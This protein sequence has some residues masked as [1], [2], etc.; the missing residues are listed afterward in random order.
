[1]R[2]ITPRRAF[3]LIEV[4]VVAVIL[5][6]LVALVLPAVQAARESARRADCASR[7]RQ[8]ALAVH[9]HAEARGHFPLGLKRTLG[10][11]SFLVQIL[12]YLEQRA[13]YEA[14]N[15][16]DDVLS[17]A[18]VTAL[19]QPP[20]VFLCPSD[21]QPTDGGLAPV[22]YAGN[23]GRDIRGG[24][25]VFLDRPLTAAEITDGLG[26]TAAVAEW[27]AGPR[28]LDAPG[29]R[30]RSVHPLRRVFGATPADR[31]AFRGVCAE[32]P[33]GEVDSRVV[34]ARVKGGFWLSGGL[35][36]SLY[37]H[38]LP[39]NRPS[40]YARTGMHAVSAGSLHPGGAHVATLDGAV[41]FVG[42]AID[43]RAWAAA[44]T[45]AGAEAGIGLDT[46]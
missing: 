34:N 8:V 18:N 11:E 45:R 37:N 20:A 19:G 31:D 3:T 44:G 38:A 16:A 27:R 41:H 25:G 39:P 6:V 9:Q 46:P 12:P 4:L 24:E 35:G 5:G 29:D 40:C 21:P 13:L 22:H 33:P 28:R 36:F 10:L 26:T 7:M 32:L 23:A 15:F 43:A 30:L 14:L 42:D 17:N 1:M 2:R